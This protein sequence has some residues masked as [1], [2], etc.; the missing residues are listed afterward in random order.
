MNRNII[1]L[2]VSIFPFINSC[3][4]VFLDIKPRGNL[5]ENLLLNK[6]GINS[7]LIG[8][9]S[10]LDGVSSQYRWESASSNWLYGDVRGLLGNIGSDSGDGDDEWPIKVYWE[11]ADNSWLYVKWREVYDADQIRKA[12]RMERKPELGMEGHRYFDLN[13]WKITVTE[14]NRALTYEK[15]TPGV[16]QCTAI[17]LLDPKT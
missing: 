4:K 12:L 7:I 10:M 6:T 9:Y 14:L 2:I 15:T 16:C 5:D 8:A 1:I 11:T 13:R 17:Q 3:R